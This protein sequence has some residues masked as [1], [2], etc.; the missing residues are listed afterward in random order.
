M[1]TILI[2][3]SFFDT[4]SAFC[5]FAT[6]DTDCLSADR[7]HVHC[8]AVLLKLIFMLKLSGDIP[9]FLCVGREDVVVELI[10]F[11]TD[12]L[13]GIATRKNKITSTEHSGPGGFFSTLNR[14]L[15]PKKNS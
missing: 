7:L 3:S 2:L 13:S 6:F 11:W 9:T 14:N 10:F 12:G 5:F 8:H 1:M 15:I 4:V